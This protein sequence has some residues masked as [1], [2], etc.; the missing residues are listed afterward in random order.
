MHKLLFLALT[1]IAAGAAAAQN[2]AP[3]AP[4]DPAAK[5]PPVEYRS[6][7]ADYRPQAEQPIAPWR[8]ANDE[9]AGAEAAHGGPMQPP[10]TQS[11][12]AVKPPAGG[13]HGGHR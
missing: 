12:P 5:V 8:A 2:A 9:V 10:P 4:T 7:F 1:A 6:A 11:K 13:E 3:P